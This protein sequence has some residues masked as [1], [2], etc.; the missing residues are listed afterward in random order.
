MKSEQF[1]Q[2]VALEAEKAI[3]GQWISIVSVTDTDKNLKPEYRKTGILKVSQFT[4][5]V[6]KAS[7]IDLLNTSTGAIEAGIEFK[8]KRP[9]YY[10]TVA[11]NGF[12][13]LL[14]S[15]PEE[16]YFIIKFNENDTKPAK[17]IYVNAEMKELK[18]EDILLE[19]K[20]GNVRTQLV[21][22]VAEVKIRNFKL[23]SIAKMSVG[24]L[25][26]IDDDLCKY[27]AIIGA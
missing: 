6:R 25:V 22:D 23:A 11:H 1:N 8:P 24:G 9:S 4:A 16:K 18:E 2:V 15:K 19:K 26:L 10:E 17:T 27:I 3:F 21:A 20:E 13:S 12:C 5:H 7:Y 14:K